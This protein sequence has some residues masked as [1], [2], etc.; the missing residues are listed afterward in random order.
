ME[1]AVKIAEE[2]HPVQV[3]LFDFVELQFHPGRELDVHDLRERLH[4]FV[5]HDRPEHRRMEPAIDLLDIFPILNRL[6]DAG[7]RA[8]PA[9]AELL[10]HLDQA[11]LGKPR[12][13][14]REMLARLTI[15]SD[16]PPVFR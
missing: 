15:R 3:L 12:R 11:R 2:L 9:D 7:I 14:L 10:E 5:R 16:T 6:D 4:Q 1:R 13:R 8:R